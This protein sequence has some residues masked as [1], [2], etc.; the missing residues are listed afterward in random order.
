MAPWSMVR[1]E[2]LLRPVSPVSIL[3][4]TPFY[5]EAVGKSGIVVARSPVAAN[6]TT[7][8]TKAQGHHLHHV[9]VTSGSVKV[10]DSVDAQIDAG[11]QLH[12][13]NHQRPT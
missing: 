5:G 13:L 3:D 1:Q 11:A 7:D 6:S 12:E 9:T 8:T 4:R 2:L 10:G